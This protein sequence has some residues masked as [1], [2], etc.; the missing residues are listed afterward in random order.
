MSIDTP[1]RVQVP[2]A[3]W[4]AL[5]LLFAIGVFNYL[6]RTIISI[7]Q[8][9]MKAELGFT[10]TQLGLLLGASFGLVY[11]TFGLPIGR[12]ADRTS[13]KGV[14]GVCLLVWT[15]LTA[16]TGFATS[17][18]ALLVCRMG[19]AIGEAGC[20]PISHSLISD[21]FPRERRAGAV[22]LWAMS[23]PLGILLGFLLGGWLS[24]AL[25][26]RHAFLWVGLAGMLLVPVTF[27]ILREPIRGALDGARAHAVLP[28]LRDVLKLMWACRSYRLI[29]VAAALHL[30]SFYATSI[31]FP[32]FYARVHHMPIR[33]VGGVM[34]LIGGVGGLIGMA[35]AGYLSDRLGKTDARWYLRLPAIA[36]ALLIPL[37][38]VQLFTPNL[39]LSVAVG[40]VNGALVQMYF[41]P[42]I[43]TTQS[44]MPARV[45]TFTGAFYVFFANVFSMSLG[46]VFVGV[47]SDRLGGGPQAL[48]IAIALAL[49]A[50][51]AAIV[52]FL[53]AA[54]TLRSDLVTTPATEFAEKAG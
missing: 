13:R 49:V 17:Y 34:A 29:L 51:A 20:A 42:M 11:T 38:L 33:E 30:F 23:L 6:D 45:R 15:G 26:W 19:V 4:V 2:R 25:G 24:H 10:D 48:S 18:A 43:A 46:P 22:A 36:E 39:G 7:L 9:P 40:V 52:V 3:S 14:L 47:I 32:Q 54:R 37:T 44:L 5:A 21:L 8:I 12:L 41:A 31:W 53:T 16:V 50:S 35:S 28:P 1:A 27:L